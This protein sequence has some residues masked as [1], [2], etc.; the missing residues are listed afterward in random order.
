MHKMLSKSGFPIATGDV[1]GDGL[2]D[3]FAGGSYRSG[4]PTIF[5]QKTGG[6]F[7]KRIVSQDS[8]HEN[9]AAVFWM[10]TKTVI[11]IC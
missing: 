4:K 2:E 8:L 7:E 6:H 10:Q 1:N 3:I 9:A 11:W 5:L